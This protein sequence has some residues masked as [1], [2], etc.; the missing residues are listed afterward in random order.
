MRALSHTAAT[1]GEGDNE[2]DKTLHVALEISLSTKAAQPPTTIK[3]TT[4]VG[5]VG[6][7]EYTREIRKPVTVLIK[8]TT[9]TLTICFFRPTVS[10]S[11]ISVVGINRRATVNKKP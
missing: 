7:L 6:R 5:T 1:V 8:L 9:P 11:D 2:S 3:V 4:I 10:L